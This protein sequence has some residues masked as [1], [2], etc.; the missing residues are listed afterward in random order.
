M[1]VGWW[2]A[3]GCVSGATPDAPQ[4]PAAEAASGVGRV[5]EVPTRAGRR[6]VELVLDP[7]RMDAGQWISTGP[8]D[9]LV[10]PSAAQSG[11]RAVANVDPGAHVAVVRRACG[12]VRV[13]YAVG[14]DTSVVSLPYPVCGEAAPVGAWTPDD[15]DV[16]RGLD[17]FP[18]W[19]A[20]VGAR[21]VWV[22]R[23]EAEAAC[24][25]YGRT[26]TPGPV[27]GGAVWGADG[28]VVGADWGEAAPPVARDHDIGLACAG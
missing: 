15:A 1:G 2:L 23:A 10:E 18:D 4:E 28:G 27:E 16:L 14:P 17:L 5:T 8:A 22:T 7:G 12:E 21:A 9:A 11:A 20:S 19:P 6:T 24:G 25:W 26:L 3:L 13:P